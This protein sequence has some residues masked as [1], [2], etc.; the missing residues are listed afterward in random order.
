M[1]FLFSLFG[2][3]RLTGIL[4]ANENSD[5]G[6]MSRVPERSFPESYNPSSRAHFGRGGRQGTNALNGTSGLDQELLP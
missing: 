4:I 6:L 5:R 3:G 2:G 1:H